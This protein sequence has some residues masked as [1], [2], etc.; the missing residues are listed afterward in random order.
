M[1]ES[2]SSRVIPRDSHP[3]TTASPPKG[4]EFTPPPTAL[5]AHAEQL[6]SQMAEQLLPADAK[7][8]VIAVGTDRG[9][10]AAIVHRAS[11][12]FEI[13]SWVGKSWGAGLTG[14]ARVRATW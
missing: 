4:V 8:G 5:L 11:D 3:Q 7:G 1:P 13:A 6:V 2:T 12:H 9:W 14:G 10:N